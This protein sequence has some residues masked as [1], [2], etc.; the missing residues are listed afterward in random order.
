MLTHLETPWAV[1]RTILTEEDRLVVI[2]FGQDHHP[3]CIKMDE[4]LFK[5]EHQ[6]SNFACVFLVD[7]R[8]VPQFN[9]MYELYDPCTVMFFFR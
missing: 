3:E 1:D 9:T 6:V 7:N 5:I 4:V 8:K 2:R